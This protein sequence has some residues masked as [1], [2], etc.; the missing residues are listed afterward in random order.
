MTVWIVN[1]EDGRRIDS[2]WTEQAPAIARAMEL[3]RWAWRV[4][5]IAHPVDVC[6]S[7]VAPR[8]WQLPHGWDG[9]L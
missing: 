7:G 8:R 5:L 6:D 2:V 1:T 3:T 4:T 9:T